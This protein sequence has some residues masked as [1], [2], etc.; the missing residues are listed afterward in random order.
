MDKT[1]RMKPLRTAAS[2][3]FSAHLDACV[4]ACTTVYGLHINGIPAQTF[5][6]QGMPMAAGVKLVMIVRDLS[7]GKP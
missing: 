6:M 3:K 7:K 4:H 2:R 5:F 1:F